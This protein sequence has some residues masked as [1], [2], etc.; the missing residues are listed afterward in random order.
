MGRDVFYKL[1][2]LVARDLKRDEAMG[3]SSK[4]TVVPPDM[5]LAITL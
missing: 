4:R 2:R 1:L 5:R 3:S